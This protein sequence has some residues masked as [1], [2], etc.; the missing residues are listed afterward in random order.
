MEGET[1]EE[2]T[3]EKFSF[4]TPVNKV[5]HFHEDNLDRRQR[6]TMVEAIPS[7]APFAIFKL[8]AWSGAMD[9]KEMVII[10]VP[11]ALIH[12]LK[13]M[14]EVPMVGTF[15]VSTARIQPAHWLAELEEAT[16]KC[17]LA[18]SAASRIRLER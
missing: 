17:F 10:F 2:V 12:L 1:K 15:V 14:G 7:N 11:S 9:T 13:I 16:L 18:H 8:Y 5:G 3:L 4:V 6:W